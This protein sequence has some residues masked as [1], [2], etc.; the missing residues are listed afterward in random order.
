MLTPPV[1]TTDLRE[2]GT[3]EDQEAPKIYPKC[4]FDVPSFVAPTKGT[5]M[6]SRFVQPSNA[7][8]PILVTLLGITIFV[9]LLQPQKAPTPM[10]VTLSG[11]VMLVRLVQRP[12][13]E[14]PMLVTLSGSVMLVR[15]VQL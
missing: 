11:S 3:P 14:F 4:V 5:V 12:S 7:E 8:E 1:I 13:A 2:V 15:L 9:R 10:L 6:R